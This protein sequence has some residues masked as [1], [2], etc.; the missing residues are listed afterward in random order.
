MK[1]MEKQKIEL[2]FTDIGLLLALFNFV[3]AI[4]TYLALNSGKNVIELNYYMAQLISRLW[5]YFFAVK[6]IASLFFFVIGYTA[7]RIIKIWN[8][9]KIVLNVCKLFMFG[10]AFFFAIISFHNIILSKSQAVS[11]ISLVLCQS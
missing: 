7:D 6:I 3:D 2:S 11:S 10:L 1:Y 9:P 4:S 5:Y 8:I